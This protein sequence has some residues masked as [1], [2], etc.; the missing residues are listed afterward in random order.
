MDF[1]STPDGNS[2]RDKN[3]ILRHNAK[4]PLNKSPAGATAALRDGKRERRRREWPIPFARSLTKQP[5][6]KAPSLRVAVKSG[7]HCV[8]LFGI[9]DL[10]TTCVVRLVIIP[11]LP[12]NALCGGL[13]QKFLGS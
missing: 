7:A 11:I 8:A 4:E 1:S 5:A 3:E 13:I 9:V 2:G 6:R 12:S 10:A